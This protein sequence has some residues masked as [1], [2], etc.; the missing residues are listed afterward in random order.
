[1]KTQHRPNSAKTPAKTW[2]RPVGILLAISLAGL[3]WWAWQTGVVR[4]LPIGTEIPINSGQVTPLVPVP[5]LSPGP[6]AYQL[7]AVN[8]QI[9]LVPLAVQSQEKQPEALLKETLNHLFNDP[10]SSNLS[11]AIPAGTHLKN[12]RIS[13][14][15][16]YI[17]LSR[18]FKQGGGSASMIYRV[19]QVLYTATSIDPNSKV[20]LS[21]EGQPIDEAHPLGGEGLVLDRPLTRKQ[22]AE[23]FPLEN[24]TK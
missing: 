23:N 8:N 16:V 22:L 10:Q 9:Q 18:E 24:P 15:A 7:R 20:Y 3:G 2:R 1:M 19:A 4:Q 12:L 13:N 11:T 5:P 14:G 17:D 6:Q 21:V